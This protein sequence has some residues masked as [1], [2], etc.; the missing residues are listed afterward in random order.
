MQAETLACDEAREL[1][2]CFLPATFPDV[3]E[4]GRFAA[5]IGK[6]SHDL[7]LNS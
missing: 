2:A 1:A 3:R 5:S 4:T 6:F 7:L